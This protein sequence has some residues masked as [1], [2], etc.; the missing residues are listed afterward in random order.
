MSKRPRSSSSSNVLMSLLQK[1]EFG[2]FWLSL[3]FLSILILKWYVVDPIKIEGSP[4]VICIVLLLW[5]SS[6][7]V[8]L[9]IS[10]VWWAWNSKAQKGIGLMLVLPVY[11]LG[12]VFLADYMLLRIVPKLYYS[13]ML[14]WP[15]AEY[16]YL[17]DDMIN[18][19]VGLLLA[20]AVVY[21]MLRLLICHDLQDK[22]IV[23]PVALGI[24]LATASLLLLG[25][26]LY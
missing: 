9:L 19:G 5:L 6:I 11:I 23:I 1:D 17:I 8:A 21:G 4:C 25:I 2:G 7:V 13:G 10:A 3:L 14:S 26:K 22:K 16:S 12:C 15:E 18:H 24:M 20:T